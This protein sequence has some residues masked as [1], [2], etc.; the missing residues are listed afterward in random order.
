VFIAVGGRHGKLPIAEGA[1]ER[2]DGL[3]VKL[4][5]YIFESQRL[6]TRDGGRL[7]IQEGQTERLEAIAASL[8]RSYEQ[9]HLYI[10]KLLELLGANY[11]I[12][13]FASMVRLD[14][15]LCPIADCFLHPRSR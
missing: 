10:Q 14:P 3:A 15:H 1:C 2:M 11:G 6:F 8:T 9:T 7:T 13:K 5:S 4:D 12:K